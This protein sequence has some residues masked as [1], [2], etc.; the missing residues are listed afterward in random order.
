M[1]RYFPHFLCACIMVVSLSGIAPYGIFFLFHPDTMH[2]GMLLVYNAPMPDPENK[3]TIRK[4]WIDYSPGSDTIFI[5][6]PALTCQC[7]ANFRIFCKS[8]LYLSEYPFCNFSVIE[9]RTLII[10]PNYQGGFSSPAWKLCHHPCPAEVRE[11]FDNLPIQRDI[12]PS[13]FWQDMPL[14]VQVKLPIHQADLLNYPVRVRWYW[15]P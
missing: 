4:D 1:S 12:S 9:D 3:N 15:L 10:N 11:Q 14:N 5:Q 6:S 7:F 2:S 13:P 8:G